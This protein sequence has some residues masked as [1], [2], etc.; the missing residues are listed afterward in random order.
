MSEYLMADSANGPAS[1]SNGDL[2][3]D[4][5]NG[6]RRSTSSYCEEGRIFKSTTAVLLFLFTFVHWSTFA[7][8]GKVMPRIV[9]AAE[10]GDHDG[11]QW[12]FE[13]LKRVGLEDIA[14]GRSLE[15]VCMFILYIQ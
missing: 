3:F 13:A 11:H 4:N 7:S 15:Q 8:V 9:N 1:S 14:R 6:R 2:S 12:S 10:D 5:L